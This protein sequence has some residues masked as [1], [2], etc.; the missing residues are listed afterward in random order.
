LYELFVFLVASSTTITFSLVSSAEDF[1]STFFFYFF[2]F[3]AS[4]E[5]ER[6]ANPFPDEE[7]FIIVWS[8]LGKEKKSSQIRVERGIDTNQKEK[9]REAV[10]VL[11]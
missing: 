3:L 10:D 1:L 9:E 4:L 5:L 6:A 2:F 8:E 7:Y 11:R